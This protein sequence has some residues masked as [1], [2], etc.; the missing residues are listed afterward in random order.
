LIA[1]DIPRTSCDD[2]E[3]ASYAPFTADSKDVIN[4]NRQNLW[5]C[6]VKASMPESVKV[7]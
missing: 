5:P 1:Q 4:P 3:F 7:F 6:V 2:D